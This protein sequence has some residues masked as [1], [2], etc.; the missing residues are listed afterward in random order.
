MSTCCQTKQALGMAKGGG[1]TPPHCMQC[2]QS[3]QKQQFDM[4]ICHTHM[5]ITSII[6]NA[7]ERRQDEGM[8]VS[9][10]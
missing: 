9:G 1:T 8:L 7:L 4:I 2:M 3:L 10:D 6:N 5:C